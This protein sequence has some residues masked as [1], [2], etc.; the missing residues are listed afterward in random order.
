MKRYMPLS[1]ILLFITFYCSIYLTKAQTLEPP[2][3]ENDIVNIANAVSNSC[4]SCNINNFRFWPANNIPTSSSIVKTVKVDFN[5][6][7]NGSGGG[8][9]INNTTDLQNGIPRL[10]NIL[11]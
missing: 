9:F 5:V 10:I 11:G 3:F 1:I 8:N 2:N 7:Q 4:S 6:L